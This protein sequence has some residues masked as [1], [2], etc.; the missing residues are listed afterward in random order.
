MT[1][2]SALRAARA[3]VAS[4]YG[5]ALI[6]CALT[7]GHPLVLGAIAVVLVISIV[8]SGARPPSRRAL[9]TG[10]TLLLALPVLV[11]VLVSRSGLTVF[12]RLGDWGPLGQEN[13]T[14]EALVYGLTMGLR[15]IDVTLVF[16]LLAH[17]VDGD[18][19]LRAG[20]RV[21]PGSALTA[22]LTARLAGVLARDA[23]RLADARRCRPDDG[24]DRLLVLRATVTSALDRSLD[25]AAALELRGYGGLALRPPADARP[26][27]RHDIAFTTAAV[28]VLSATIAAGATGYATFDCYPTVHAAALSHAVVLSALLALL[29]LAPSC[30]RRGVA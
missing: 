29:S 8:T 17:T 14:V 10:A 24:H 21:W 9:L 22:A 16:V 18:Q 27:S 25:V 7:Q 23:R 6:V 13:L 5:A 19:L 1:R 2:P 28:A 3:T 4:A 26:W 11:N 20:R 12:A 30:A 15:L